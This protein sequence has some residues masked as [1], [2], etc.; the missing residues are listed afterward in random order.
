MA[1]AGLL[2]IGKGAAAVLPVTDR[3]GVA[4]FAAGC[5]VAGH[6]WSIFLRWAG[7]RGVGPALG[8]TL[9]LAWPGTVVLGVGL[10]AGRLAAHTATGTFAAQAALPVVLGVTDGADGVWLGIAL[11]VPMWIKR[12]VG[13]EAPPGGHGPAATLFRLVRD[14][15]PV[16]GEA[17]DGTAEPRARGAE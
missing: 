2:D 9:V 6:N 13:S 14:H 7:G 16:P 4:A 8:A 3:P 11:L 5:V 15:D 12:V 17:R 1:V 10:A